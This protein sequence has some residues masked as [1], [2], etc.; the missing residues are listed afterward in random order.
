MR[1]VQDL[2]ESWGEAIKEALG[3]RPLAWLAHEVGVNPST[4]HRIVVG[5][6]K[7]G[8]RLCPSDELK[9]KIA[10]ALGVRMDRLWAWPA[11]VPPHQKAS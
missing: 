3:D 1:F 5:H 4:I 11:I 10:G 8:R 7:T 9:W 6:P 2:H